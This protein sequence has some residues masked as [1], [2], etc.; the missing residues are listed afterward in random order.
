MKKEGPLKGQI[1]LFEKKNHQ[2]LP[3]KSFTYNEEDEQHLNEIPLSSCLMGNFKMFHFDS[4]E[5]QKLTG[6][7]RKLLLCFSNLNPTKLQLNSQKLVKLINRFD[8]GSLVKIEASGYGGFICISSLLSGG[9]NAPRKITFELKNT[10]LALFPKDILPGLG[11]KSLELPTH[12]IIISK[13]E[14][15]WFNPLEDLDSSPKYL[16]YHLQFKRSC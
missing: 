5:K 11:K 7:M 16:D 10:P 6:D 13:D 9:I 14:S 2:D 1:L 15:C 12:E 8:K 4:N 3:L